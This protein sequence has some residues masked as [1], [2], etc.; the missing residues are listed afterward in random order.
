MKPLEK[1]HINAMLECPLAGMKLKTGESI[2][3]PVLVRNISQKTF[4]SDP[5]NG[6]FVSYKWFTDAGNIGYPDS[7]FSTP[8]ESPILPGESS[9]IMTRVKAPGDEGTYLL[10]IF[11]VQIKCLV[12][13]EI[14]IPGIT[15]TRHQRREFANLFENAMKKGDLND[16]LEYYKEDRKHFGV[17]VD[18]ENVLICRV[19]GLKEW[20]HRKSLPYKIC[21]KSKPI[22]IFPPYSP[23]K[24][25]HIQSE[26]IINSPELYV[27]EVRDAVIIGGHDLVL[28]GNDIGLVDEY[29]GEKRG[30]DTIFFEDGT[31]SLEARDAL[32]IRLWKKDSK[33]PG[34]PIERGIILCGMYAPNY[35]HWMVDFLPRIWAINQ[36]PEYRSY[37]LII[38]N[39]VPEKYIEALKAIDTNSRELI[40]LEYGIRYEVKDLVVPSRVIRYRP[41]MHGTYKEFSIAPVAIN[42]LRKKL[43]TY[44]NSAENT[45]PKRIYIERKE[46][47]YRNLL[48]ENEIKN[49]FEKYQFEFIDPSELSISRQIKLFSSADII[50]GP[51][52]AG[53]TNMI[54]APSHVQGLMLLGPQSSYLYSNIAHLIGQDLIH[55]NGECIMIESLQDKLQ[56]DY[57]INLKEVGF[58][59]DSVIGKN[60]RSDKHKTL[61]DATEDRLLNTEYL[62]EISDHTDYS[63][64]Q[65]NKKG[66]SDDPIIIR[67]ESGGQILVEGWAIDGKARLPASAVFVSFDSGKE[68]RAYYSI[69]R[70]DVAAHFG[71]DELTY[72]GF[73]SVI[74]PDELPVGDRSFRVK[75]VTHDRQGY[76]Y[77]PERFFIQMS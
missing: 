61:V 28:I 31:I 32:I 59:L 14:P 10:K 55:I 67:K 18:D 22:R 57:A 47:L 66:I 69:C 39:N 50:A 41:E 12:I 8:I 17:G 19:L 9:R 73:A 54:F 60:S 20:C 58:A 44:W 30:H 46:P 40:R 51:H 68:Y 3:I 15:V 62:P 42:F 6:I 1:G 11:L 74:S 72:S 48:N 49:L 71:V 2:T 5:P 25:K 24:L 76:Y 33:P 21:E 65:I 53:W 43:T 52:G 56:C 34:P 36:C 77:P 75:I 13:S 63:V 7:A 38:D 16:A 64:D 35:F 29:T 70:P 45:S 37:P 23:G 4:D 27:A 26:G